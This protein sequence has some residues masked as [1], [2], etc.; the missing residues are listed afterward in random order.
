MNETKRDSARFQQLTVL[1]R[2]RISVDQRI[3]AQ[4]ELLELAQRLF[5]TGND[6]LI[7]RLQTH[8]R[9]AVTYLE[10]GEDLKAL[11]V[12]RRLFEKLE[13]P[14]FTQEA[15]NTVQP[16]ARIE[17]RERMLEVTDRLVRLEAGNPRAAVLHANQ[18][19][20]NRAPIPSQFAVLK[21]ALETNPDN[22][23]LLT[24][25]LRCAAGNI[26]VPEIEAEAEE[27]G[28]RLV[29]LYPTP[30]HFFLYGRLLLVRGKQQEAFAAFDR[31]GPR[32]DA[33]TLGPLKGPLVEMCAACNRNYYCSAPSELDALKVTLA[34]SRQRLEAFLKADTALTAQEFAGVIGKLMPVKI[35]LFEFARQAK[36]DVA[37]GDHFGTFDLNAYVALADSLTEHVLL[38]F[39][40]ALSPAVISGPSKSE[41]G[42]FKLAKDYCAF[43]LQLGDAARARKTLEPLAPL[44][45]VPRLG[46]LLRDISAF[47]DF[48]RGGKAVREVVRAQSS[49]T[50]HRMAQWEAWASA[51]NLSRRVIATTP[52]R[53]IVYSV[54]QTDGSLQQGSYRQDAY[55]FETVNAAVKLR[56]SELL[57]GPGGLL[58][59]AHPIHGRYPPT[60][61]AVIDRSTHSALIRP[62]ETTS[63]VEEPVVLFANNDAVRVPSYGHWLMFLLNR[64]NAAIDHGLLANRK[65]LM[66]AE[67]S[68]WMKETLRLIGIVEEQIIFYPRGQEMSVRDALVVSTLDFS[69]SDLY[70]SLRA[71]IRQGAGVEI[72]DWKNSAAPF[73]FLS[74]KAQL[75]RML[76]DEDKICA[77][78]QKLGYTIV[79]PETLSIADQVRLFSNAAAVV[80][81]G[82]SAFANVLY[83]EDGARILCLK[84]EEKVSP[85]VLDLA[86][87]NNLD[88]RWLLGRSIPSLVRHMHPLDAPFRVDIDDLERQ[89]VWA[90]EAAQR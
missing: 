14:R 67:L 33:A 43:L 38:L 8:H 54:V 19:K 65:L 63:V 13:D 48:E 52:K 51:Q 40:H 46:M 17:A 25:A 6:D 62:P 39:E 37:L 83:C 34:A 7:A 74:R 24:S 71:R 28:K 35:L 45:A 76:L 68:G 31:I 87:A 12:A 42:L 5:D 11:A 80:G 21:K 27:Y 72:V 78:A 18:L 79:S 75:R 86:V 23:G 50:L 70:R 3:A 22:Q 41:T 1:L 85:F 57:I 49:A 56:E 81:P 88:F 47:D 90:K 4:H 30:G 36:V 55:D 82:G 59:E 15:I 53:E 77:L 10:L 58:L 64:V 73:V 2:S 26:R 20:R 44:G 61:P 66:P 32:V 84:G 69:S 9:L 29:E 60:L 16:V 89:L